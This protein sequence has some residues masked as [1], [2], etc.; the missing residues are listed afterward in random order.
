MR[1]RDRTVVYF[2]WNFIE[3]S[4]EGTEW[5]YVIVGSGNYFAANMQQ[6]IT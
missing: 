4:S 2:D 6:V 1:F 5:W 3:M